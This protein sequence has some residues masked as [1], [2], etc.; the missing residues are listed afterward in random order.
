MT[1]SLDGT[2]ALR[3]AAPGGFAAWFEA[4]RGVTREQAAGAMLL[5]L[6]AVSPRL[7]QVALFPGVSWQ[8]LVTTAINGQLWSFSLLLAIVV[9]DRHADR[10]TNRLVAYGSAVLVAAVGGMLLGVAHSHFVWDVFRMPDAAMSA[11]ASVISGVFYT[12]QVYAVLETSLIG[13][14][15]AYVYVDRREAARMA[16]RLHQAG[17]RRSAQVRAMVESELQAMQARVEPAFLF[18]TLGRVRELY[19]TDPARG[20]R[21]LDEL[22]TYLR[23]AMPHLRD[24]ASTIAQEMDLLRAYLVI[25]EPPDRLFIGVDVPASLHAA[26]I[27]SALVLPLALHLLTHRTA[28]EGRATLHLRA[29]ASQQHVAIDMHLT[30]PCAELSDAAPQLVMVR[31]RLAAVYDT[32]ATL[33]LRAATPDSAGLTLALPNEAANSPQSE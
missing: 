31:E 15:A 21:I 19:D 32:A 7:L 3:L 28:L 10:G 27:P 4:W 33:E 16:T 30:A 23:A 8:A 29:R 25:V 22:I 20:D 9:A 26:R 12:I 11:K 13:A 1:A 5:G 6:A 17:L 24:T 14:L 2:S 18:D